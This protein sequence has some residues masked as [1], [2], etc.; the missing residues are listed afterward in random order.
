MV[1]NLENR[2]SPEQVLTQARVAVVISASD[3]AHYPGRNRAAI[4]RSAPPWVVCQYFDEGRLDDLL[5][6]PDSTDFAAIMVT[7]GA[8]QL[9]RVR[10]ALSNH[11]ESIWRYIDQGGGFAVIATSLAPERRFRFVPHPALGGV[12]VRSNEAVSAQTG[13]V[14]LADPFA[15]G[16]GEVNTSDTMRELRTS[17]EIAPD[18][19]EHWA[20]AAQLVSDDAHSPLIRLSRKEQ[21]VALCCVHVDDLA[22][23]LDVDDSL[24]TLLM[25]WLVRTKTHLVLGD[26]LPQ[27]LAAAAGPVAVVQVRRRSD[28]RAIPRWA[29]HLQV[30]PGRDGS[31]VGLPL[32]RHELLRFLEDQGTVSFPAHQC[33]DV[34]V[35]A[36]LAGEPPYMERVH[37][38]GVVAQKAEIWNAPTFV[39]LAYAALVAQV[40][41]T[42]QMPYRIPATL[43]EQEACRV[44]SIVLRK[45]IVDGSSGRLLL[46]TANLYAAANLLN[47][48]FPELSR[49]RK[50]MIAASREPDVDPVQLWGARWALHVARDHDLLREITRPSQA[51]SS[52]PGRLAHGL[53]VAILQYDGTAERIDT[54]LLSSMERALYRL[55]LSREPQYAA[56]QEPAGISFERPFDDPRSAS[57]EEHLLTA[58]TSTRLLSNYPLWSGSL[59]GSVADLHSPQ[60]GEVLEL[61]ASHRLE[62]EELRSHFEIELSSA[63]STAKKLLHDQRTLL[64]HHGWLFASFLVFTFMLAALTNSAPWLLYL[65][66]LA[67][68]SDAVAVSV[69]LLPL[70][71]ALIFA[72]QR[73]RWFSLASPRWYRETLRSLEIL[74]D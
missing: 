12:E 1:A 50:W 47:I 67:S 17:V 36:R 58:T 46:P 52:V 45:R 73:S 14:T 9:A 66:G 19:D 7:P 69:V 51:P 57:L 18:A 37:R 40:N 49:V 33:D 4:D 54:R 8:M 41:E 29:G 48:D 6:S 68:L 27:G 64:T 71:I 63:Q 62:I 20:T 30:T 3:V 56:I 23:A 31:A 53:D 44:V 65:N 32:K 16:P 22:E 13:K 34:M 28:L 43:T 60:R 15:S 70:T 21:R 72:A 10:Q 61:E 11:S 59:S 35:L 25:R 55:A 74:R 42:V 39:Q 24:F 2:V 26:G 5:L 38:A